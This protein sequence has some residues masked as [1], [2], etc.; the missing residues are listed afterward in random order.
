MNDMNR[1][2][3]TKYSYEYKV[4]CIALYRQGK[5]PET[6]KGIGQADYRK[7]IRRWVRK[8]ESCGL[9]AIRHR[10]SNRVWSAEEKYELVAKVL[11]GNSCNSVAIHE[12]IEISM[13]RHW[14]KTYKIKGYEGLAVQR[15][16]QP[17]KE[18]EMKK[19]TVTT[20]PTP[21]EREELIWLK[22]EVA[23]LKAENEVIKK[24]IALR[25][26]KRAAQLK[27]RKQRSSK[28]SAKKDIP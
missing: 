16:G 11:A 15:K 13:L 10:E 24:E 9:E 19:K 23:Y 7:M 3:H 25:E 4:M 8:E 20:E 6:P 27:A 1:F 26:G 28:N 5:W 14:V 18:S 12:G 21:S 17:P 22:A 2:T